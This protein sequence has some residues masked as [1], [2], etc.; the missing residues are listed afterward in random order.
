MTDDELDE[1][2]VAE[3]EET[4]RQKEEGNVEGTRRSSRVSN[5]PKHL[6]EYYCAIALSADSYLEEIPEDIDEI[7]NREDK[8]H[9]KKTVQDEIDS[10]LENETWDLVELPPGK[11]A[12]DY[13]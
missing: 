12:I 10:L 2:S 4:T 8:R 1:T 6:E 13:R 5:K 7:E 3:S 11:K 9:W